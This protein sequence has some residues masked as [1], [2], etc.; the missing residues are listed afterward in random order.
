MAAADRAESVRRIVELTGLGIAATY[1]LDPEHGPG[2]RRAA[3]RWLAGAVADRRHETV[4]APV[5]HE[6]PA[7]APAPPEEPRAV[8]E[9]VV[10]VTTT[11]APAL[12]QPQ[13]PQW[14]RWGW[15]LVTTITLCAIAATA[16][17]GIGSWAIE[18]DGSTVTVTT[19]T[20]PAQITSAAQILADPTARR[21][22]GS[23]TTGTVVLRTDSAGSALALAGLPQ[24]PAAH[25]YHVWVNA[26]RIAGFTKTAALLWIPSTLTGGDRVTV[27]RDRAGA[28]AAAAHGPQFASVVVPP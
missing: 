28:G 3:R 17:V 26:K 4:V 9:E 18:T 15:A 14:P 7:P 8:R 11:P 1:F 5:E 24:L 23:A 21:I 12:P 6:E 25:V 10:V 20:V 19:A 13:E 16:A 2:R 27:T 22:T